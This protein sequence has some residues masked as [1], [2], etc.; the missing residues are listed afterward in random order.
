MTEL[1]D[2]FL[3]DNWQEMDETAQCELVRAL[4]SKCL[5]GY[6]VEN[7]LPYFNLVDPQICIRVPSFIHQGTGLRFKL[8]LG[9]WYKMGMSND[10][11]ASAQVISSTLPFD[12][13]T[14]QPAHDVFIKPFLITEFPLLDTFVR[15]HIQIDKGV[16]RPDFTDVVDGSFAPIYLTRSEIDEIKRKT[17]FC[18][19]SE[20]QWEY[21]F[22][23][24][25]KT[26]FNFGNSLPSEAELE[27]HMLSTFENEV[28]CK[29][30]ANAFGLVG[31]HVGDWCED[32][33]FSRLS[34]TASDQPILGK[35]PFVVR[36]G[37][38]PYWPW[39]TNERW[40]LCVSSMR[41]S[42]EP[43]VSCGAHLVKNLNL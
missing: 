22:R 31:L 24:G 26:L 18:L 40:I 2:K 21:A 15:K 30:N 36:G 10:E 37:A 17:C 25:T 39:E 11:L 5:H 16:F 8:I 28:L 3:L 23:G 19:P 35:S 33:Y 6:S 32:S 20:A 27:I 43:D 29:K 13:D 14:L 38:A 4:A 1:G 42:V 7:I 34:T 9:G 12:P 41:W